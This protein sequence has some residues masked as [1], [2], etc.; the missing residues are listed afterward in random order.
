MRQVEA[1]IVGPDEHAV[2]HP[3]CPSPGSGSRQGS[4]DVERC[5]GIRPAFDVH[6]PRRAAARKSRPARVLHCPEGIWL[7]LAPEGL[8]LLR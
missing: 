8:R 1:S 5:G 3:P 2:H 7:T 4:R 6:P